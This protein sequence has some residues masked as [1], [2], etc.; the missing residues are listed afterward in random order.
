MQARGHIIA[1]GTSWKY[2]RAVPPKLEKL[3]GLKLWSHG[4]GRI[5]YPDAVA[6]G[7][8]YDASYDALVQRLSNLPED[9]AA[10][11]RA[12]KGVRGLQ[13][14]DQAD[15]LDEHFLSFLA[16][17]VEG[18]S[19]QAL[20]WAKKPMPK[21]KVIELAGHAALASAALKEQ[22]TLLAT[23][24]AQRRA[25]LDRL[26]PEALGKMSVLV[27]KWI[28][29]AAPRSTGTPKRM[30]RFI[31][32][33]INCCGDLDPRDVTRQDAMK[34]RDALAKDTSILKSAHKYLHGMSRLFNVG[35]SEGLTDTNPFQ[36]IEARKQQ[37]RKV[38]DEKP[39]KRFTSEQARDLLAALDELDLSQEFWRDFR[40]T[41]RLMIY[42]GCRSGEL[43]NLTPSDVHI[44]NSIP[45]FELHDES[46]DASVKNLSS[47]RQVPLHPACSELITYADAAK[48]AGNKYLFNSY[49]QWAETRVG[50]FQQQATVLLRE[51]LGI[52][53]KKIKAH[54]SR[55][56]WR[57][58]ANEIEMPGNISRSIVGHSL[59]KDDHDGTYGSTPSLK[60][61]YEWLKKIDPFSG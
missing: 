3:A 47:M 6:K 23:K 32:R 40:L 5:S 33:F 42:H 37:G 25:T 51:T 13:K 34:Y 11:L 35:M 48:K 22:R 29:V 50:K 46:E 17:D 9:E 31:E 8:I 27:D 36:G 56:Y 15:K 43:G 12:A 19:P 14:A 55:H 30:R 28:E 10:K 16:R 41:F 18:F 57:Y 49:P 59:G 44:V 26:K 20:A 54:S 58:L 1:N 4:L 60:K 21:G 53:D 24:M 7:R 52:K 61:R 2:Q 45:V 39:G 38:A